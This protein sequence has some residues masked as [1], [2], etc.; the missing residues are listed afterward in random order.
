VIPPFP[1]SRSS[2]RPTSSDTLC[3]ILFVILGPRYRPSVRY[4]SDSRPLSPQCELFFHFRRNRAPNQIVA[5]P[6]VSRSFCLIPFRFSFD[7]S[8]LA[9]SLRF[10]SDLC[11]ITAPVIF[12]ILWNLILVFPSGPK[13]SWS[14]LDILFFSRVLLACL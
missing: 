1:A 5:C 13:I 14:Q 11:S 8:H 9:L 3:P 12:F 2:F 4:L 7:R 10:C 6:N